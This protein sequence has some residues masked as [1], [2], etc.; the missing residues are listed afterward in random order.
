VNTN[1]GVFLKQILLT[2]YNTHLGYSRSKIIFIDFDSIGSLITP[3]WMIT[4]AHC[5]DIFGQNQTNEQDCLQQTSQ[6]KT[7]RK[8]YNSQSVCAY[9]SSLAVNE[10]GQCTRSAFINRVYSLFINFFSSRILTLKGH[11]SVFFLRQ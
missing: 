6:G 11:F 10:N 1:S 8:E 2:C 9:D 5:T 3:S 4:A 7:Y